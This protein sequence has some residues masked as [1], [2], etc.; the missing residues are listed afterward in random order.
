VV[1]LSLLA[2]PLAAAEAGSPDDGEDTGVR[3]YNVSSLV[4]LVSY[5]A[6][7]YEGPSIADVNEDGYYDLFLGNHDATPIQYFLSDGDGTYTEQPSPLWRGDVHGIAPGDY[8]RDDDLDVLIALGGGNATSPQ[9]PRLKR[10]DD[11]SFSQDVTEQVGISELGARGRSVRWVDLDTDGDLDMIQVNAKPAPS[12]TGP[13]NF[14]FE[15]TGDGKFTYRKSPA[16]E[17]ITADKVLVTDFNHDHIPDLITFGPWDSVGFWKGDNQFGFS[18]VTDEVLPASVRGSK[19]VMAVAEADI[20]NDGDLDYYLARGSTGPK[21]RYRYDPAKKRLD[22]TD[23]GNKGHDGIAFTADH[24][25]DLVDFYHFPRGGIRFLPVFLG[26]DKTKI[27]TPVEIRYIKV[28]EAQGFPETLDETGWYLGHV[29]DGKWRLEWQLNDNIGWDIRGSVINVNTVDTDW[30]GP[31]SRGVPD[32]LLRNDGDKFTDISGQ[33]PKESKDDNAGVNAADFDNDGRVDFFVYRAGPLN[34]RIVDVLMLNTGN[35]FEAVLDHGATDL[36]EDATG[37]L[38]AAFD[39]DLDGKVDILTGANGGAWQLYRNLTD[40]D[41][42]GHF[43]LVRVGHSPEGV[44]PY[45]AEVRLKTAA[46]TQLQRVGSSSAAFSQSLLNT[47]HFG[48]GETAQVDSLTVR[49]RDGSEQAVS[50]DQVNRV[51]EVGRNY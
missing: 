45:G 29:G 49:W 43:V 11:G 23:Q 37:Q 16:F 14:M 44:D 28:S 33:L 13:R 3:F 1:T 41:Q 19:Q 18:N 5:P 22:I 8:D 51:I 34:Q 31:E 27:E 24:G 6:L 50:V 39:Y 42:M 47:L 30:K 46:G 4:G 2:G 32:V 12:E 15:N 9:P 17:E 7:K 26:K 35:G 36:S 21:D 20:D 10:N 40:Q 48:L 38:G 25:V